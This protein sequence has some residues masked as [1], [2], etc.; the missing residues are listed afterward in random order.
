MIAK[1]FAAENMLA[2]LET[3]QKELG[4][5]ALIISVRNIPANPSWQVWRKP[6]V[7]VVAMP[8]MAAQKKTA[9]KPAPLANNAAEISSEPNIGE[10][11]EKTYEEKAADF[12]SILKKETGLPK[13]EPRE[14][15]PPNLKAEAKPAAAQP[16]TEKAHGQAASLPRNLTEVQD[17]LMAQGVDP[18]IVRRCI[19]IAA[20]TL[21][22]RAMQNDHAV[23]D[24][25]RAQLTAGLRTRAAATP[26]T[27][28][29]P[30][31]G[32]RVIC[33]IGTSGAGKTSTTAKIAATA[34]KS[35][36]RQVAW[37]SADT[38]RAGAIA[39]TRALTDP[40]GIPLLLAY[41]ADE[42]AEEANGA[43]GADLILVDTPGCNPH[44]EQEIVELGSF[45]TSLAQRHTT[46]IAPA[47][48][49]ADDLHDALAAF[50]PFDVKSMILTK[51][52]ETR[53]WGDIYNFARTSRL[54]I[55]YYT[56][57]ARVL[58]DLWRADA[59]I[60]AGALLGEGLPQ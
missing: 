11:A 51:M 9:P 41:S 36:S 17:Q 35:L 20:E 3:I 44:C 14:E 48:A 57:G 50:A 33:L 40:L 47:T 46:L 29:L 45:L 22:P 23:R 32:M 12:L 10:K 27:P 30:F 39:K 6:G 54:P 16:K 13:R 58:G 28:G 55:A 60:L 43:L 21:S 34:S 53:R 42:L 4:P 8:S 31:G 37:I 15:P 26:Q 38:L 59:G 24:N 1:T 19:R 52:D 56:G 7:E 2:A 25:I 49:R 5:E 18:E